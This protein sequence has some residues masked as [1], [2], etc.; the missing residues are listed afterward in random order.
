MQEESTDHKD[1]KYL[2]TELI[3]S[4]EI[5][6]LKNPPALFQDSNSK[7]NRETDTSNDPPVAFSS[8]RTPF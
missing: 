5:K 1:K 4:D 3:F 6:M 8:P 2:Q 7:S